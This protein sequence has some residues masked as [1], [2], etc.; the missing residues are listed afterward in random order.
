MEF[1]AIDALLPAGHGLRFVMSQ[2]GMD[3]LPACT[4]SCT[5]HVIPSASVSEIPVIVKWQ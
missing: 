3:Y 1:Q 4:P 5:L 2:T